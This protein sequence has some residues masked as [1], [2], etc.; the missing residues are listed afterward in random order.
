MIITFMEPQRTGP[1]QDEIQKPPESETQKA[2]EVSLD[3]A[4]AVGERLKHYY[5]GKYA[6]ETKGDDTPVTT[7]DKEADDTIRSMLGA[8]YPYPI[9]SEESPDDL[10]RLESDYLWIVDPLDGT[11]SF[12]NKRG[13]FSIMIGLVKDHRAIMGLVYMPLTG[14]YYTAQKGKGAFHVSPDGEKKRLQPSLVARLEDMTLLGSVTKKAATDH[15]MTHLDKPKEMD[16]VMRLLGTQKNLQTDGSGLKLCF[17]AEGKGDIYVRLKRGASEWGRCA[18]DPIVTEAGG[19][20]TD[21][22]GH[23]ILYNRAP[24]DKMFGQLA[25]NGQ[26]HIDVLSRLSPLIDGL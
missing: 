5:H 17:V 25:T 10:S 9:L 2:F 7:A 4:Q 14:E 20:M 21:L 6:V 3:V 15:A 18:G 16:E 12:I 11:K 8:K 1:E 22:V 26:S 19:Q 23:P 24:N 13:Q